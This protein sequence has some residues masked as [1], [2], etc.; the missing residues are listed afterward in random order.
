MSRTHSVPSLTSPCVLQHPCQA[1]INVKMRA[2]LIDWLVEV[3]LKFKVNYNTIMLTQVYSKTKPLTLPNQFVPQSQENQLPDPFH[4]IYVHL[5]LM[6]ETLFLTVNVI[7]RFLAL[8]PV[9]R[10]NLQ[11]VRKPCCPL[12]CC[13]IRLRHHFN[14]HVLGLITQ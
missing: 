5:Q 13:V 12:H 8:K 7:D 1:D 11:L 10:R 2:I 3:H 4:S 14:T 6:P 9:T